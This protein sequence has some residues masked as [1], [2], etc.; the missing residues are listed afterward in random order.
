MNNDV[1]SPIDLRTMPDAK[2]WES[3]AMQKRP[4]RTEFFEAFAEVIRSLSSTQTVQ[5][6]EL[7][8]GPGFLAKHLL[9]GLPNIARYVA[10]DFSPAMHQLARQRLGEKVSRVEFVE[11]SFLEPQWPNGLGMFD[12]VV[13]HQAVHELRH[14]RH[15]SALHAEVVQRL[16]PSGIYL[17]CDHF[18][19][20]NGMKNTDLYM[21]IDEQSQAL[22]RG[23]FAAVRCLLEKEGLVLHCASI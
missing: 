17:V 1:P 3:T 8:S 22:K 4:W 10:L 2:E 16:K 20:V 11:R 5:V 19:G 14:K 6:L 15:A 21:D 18:A 7:G 13:T 12:V 9:D 23:G